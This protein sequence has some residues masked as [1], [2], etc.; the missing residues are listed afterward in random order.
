[1]ILTLLWESDIVSSNYDQF[2]FIPI[3]LSKSHEA[4]DSDDR[5][6]D[7]LR[8]FTW[9]GTIALAQPLALECWSCRKMEDVNLARKRNG[10][11]T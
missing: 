10:L 7:R 6:G 5:S 9:Y 3:K 4:F 2:R 1:M 8:N 11:K